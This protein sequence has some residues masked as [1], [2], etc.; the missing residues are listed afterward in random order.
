MGGVPSPRGL[1]MRLPHVIP[2]TASPIYYFTACT[3]KRK[4]VLACAAVH[5]ALV[6]IWTRSA[7][8]DG[9]CVGRFVIMPDHV[10]FFAQPTGEAKPRGTWLKMWKSVSARKLANASD[11]S[12]PLWQADTFDHILRNT[13]L[14]EE[15]WRYIRQNPVRAGLCINADD[16][17][18]QGEIMALRMH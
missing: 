9:W 6:D 8:L 16:W 7:K 10:H 12:T 14:Y 1:I 11:H 13:D 3:I 4:P 18:W 2:F 5:R 17:P 15:K